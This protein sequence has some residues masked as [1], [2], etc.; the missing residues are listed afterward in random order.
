MGFSLQKFRPGYTPFRGLYRSR[1]SNIHTHQ[2][3][4]L[5][6]GLLKM[7]KCFLAQ[8]LENFLRC[9]ALEGVTFHKNCRRLDMTWWEHLQ[10][11]RVSLSK[12]AG[13]AGG[14]AG[15]SVSLSWLQ[16]RSMSVDI[17]A[18]FS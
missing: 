5:G 6:F 3:L 15:W 1:W 17:F 4:W 11:T 16:Q 18:Q 2:D 13:Q 10:S 9:P 14:R 8:F 12:R 7:Q